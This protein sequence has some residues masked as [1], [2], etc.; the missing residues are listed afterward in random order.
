M[1]TKR[2]T[3][4]LLLTP[5]APLVSAVGYARVQ[6]SCYFPV[7]LWGDQF[8]TT[9]PMIISATSEWDEKMTNDL[10]TGGRTLKIGLEAGPQTRPD[11]GK[12]QTNFAYFLDGDKVLYS[13]GDLYGDPFTG[14]KLILRSPDKNCRVI[15]WAAGVNPRGSEMQSCGSESDVI[16]ELCAA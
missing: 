14:H 10:Y 2:F 8:N 11:L 7:F 6:N 4:L 16:L 15:E 12:P 9:L 5:T 3:L 13:L 1:S